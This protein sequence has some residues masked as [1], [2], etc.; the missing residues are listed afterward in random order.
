M[1]NRKVTRIG[2]NAR[3]DL[4]SIDRQAFMVK[5]RGIEVEFSRIGLGK[6]IENKSRNPN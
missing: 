2:K 3:L 1:G 5:S 6:R 4:L